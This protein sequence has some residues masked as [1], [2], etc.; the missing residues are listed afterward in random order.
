MDAC[1]VAYQN[2]ER[3]W[4]RIKVEYDERRLMNKDFMAITTQRGDKALQ[5]HWGIIQQHCSKWH[6]IQEEIAHRPESGANHED[7]V[8][9]AR[10]ILALN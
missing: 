4:H 6:G 9:F 1:V 5:N 10:R 7:V 3:Y 2:S 8:R